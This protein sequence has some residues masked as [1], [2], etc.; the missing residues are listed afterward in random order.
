M[1]SK[2]LSAPKAREATRAPE[3][4]QVLRDKLGPGAQQALAVTA[5]TPATQEERAPMALPAVAVPRV[6]EAIR[7][8]LDSRVPRVLQDLAVPLAPQATWVQQASQGSPATR[9]P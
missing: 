4:I 8:Q 6:Q 7:A 2:G 5:V 1:D 9:A 3:E